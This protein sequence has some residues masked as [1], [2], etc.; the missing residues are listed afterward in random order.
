MSAIHN[1]WGMFFG[2]SSFNQDLSQWDVSS[3]TDMREMFAH[4]VAFNWDLSKWDVSSV[5]DMQSM[6]ESSAFQ[7]QLCGDAWINSEA[8]KTDMFTDSPGSISSTV[9][10]TAKPGYGGDYG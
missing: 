3:V 9:C 5:T 7:H 2:A 4:A 8:D 6:F 1:M 10:T